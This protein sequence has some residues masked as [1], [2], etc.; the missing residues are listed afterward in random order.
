[1]ADRHLVEWVMA[2]AWLGLP[3]DYSAYLLRRHRARREASRAQE[4]RP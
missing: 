4:V 1:M 2:G 3:P